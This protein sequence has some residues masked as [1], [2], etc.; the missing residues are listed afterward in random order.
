MLLKDVNIV[1][2]NKLRYPCVVHLHLSWKVLY[3]SKN[4]A[5]PN[6]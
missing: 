1:N 6:S 5:M 2:E 4:V 3:I